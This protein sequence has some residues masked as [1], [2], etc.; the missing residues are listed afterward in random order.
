MGSL[1]VTR[2]TAYL[3]VKMRLERIETLVLW[4]YD[5]WSFIIYGDV[6]FPS[7]QNLDEIFVCNNVNTYLNVA[8]NRSTET[9]KKNSLMRHIKVQNLLLMYLLKKVGNVKPSQKFFFWWKP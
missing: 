7:A 5:A 4:A 8:L 1:Q 9:L 3:A 2:S 6:N